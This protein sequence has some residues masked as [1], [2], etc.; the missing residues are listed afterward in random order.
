M[1]KVPVPPGSSSCD[2]SPHC[3]HQLFTGGGTFFEGNKTYC[4]YAREDRPFLFFKPRLKQGCLPIELHVPMPTTTHCCAL[5]SVPCRHRLQRLEQESISE[6]VWLNVTKC[7]LS[8][9]RVRQSSRSSSLLPSARPL[10]TASS[11]EHCDFCHLLICVL[12]DCPPAKRTIG[13]SW[14]SASPVIA[15]FVFAV[16]NPS[17]GLGVCM[18]CVVVRADRRLVG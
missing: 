2:Q 15:L 11:P 10:N 13:T 7:P 4:G 18:S 9:I 6:S 14:F 3:N 8:L 12:W 5:T 17:V 1:T 16:P